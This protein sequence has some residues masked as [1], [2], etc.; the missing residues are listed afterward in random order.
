MPNLGELL[1]LLL[2]A[3]SLAVMMLG[4]GVAFSLAAISLLF[5]ALGAALGVFEVRMLSILPSRFYSV[6]QNEVLV[7]VPLFILSLIH[8]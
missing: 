6:M 8:I 7:A 2:L 5:A 3:S 1:S 4:F